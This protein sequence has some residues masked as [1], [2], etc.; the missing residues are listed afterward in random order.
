MD[1]KTFAARVL[2]ASILCLVSGSF[3]VSY[4]NPAPYADNGNMRIEVFLLS[5]KNETYNVNEVWVTVQAGGFP[6]IVYVGYSLDE[7]SFIE[8]TTNT[9]R[10]GHTFYRSI[11]LNGL[12]DG[13]HVVEVSAQAFGL[14]VNAC[15]TV[16]FYVKTGNSPSPISTPTPTPIL[17]PTFS[18]SLSPTLSPNPS[19]NLTQTPIASPSLTPFPTQTPTLEPSPTPNKTEDDF[20]P[21]AIAAIG[22]VVAVA[23]AA[24]LVYFK[25]RRG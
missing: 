23:V 4:A 16:S 25:K 14:A 2:I 10:L 12:S 15:S 9:T 18:P 22:L 21:L 7:E 3:R 24:A 17:T 5:P 19:N 11:Q 13:S 1:R 6:G 20:A 8:L